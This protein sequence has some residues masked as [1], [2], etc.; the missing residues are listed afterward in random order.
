MTF[1]DGIFPKEFRVQNETGWLPIPQVRK[2]LNRVS[3]LCTLAEPFTNLLTGKDMKVVLVILNDISK[4]FQ[5]LRS[6]TKLKQTKKQ[7]TRL[8]KHV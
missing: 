5:L 2:H 7:Y 1:L 4:S 6:W 8:W 3:A